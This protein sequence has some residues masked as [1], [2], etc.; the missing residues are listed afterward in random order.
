MR[1]IVTSGPSFSAARAMS[2][3]TSTESVRVSSSD[4]RSGRADRADSITRTGES[5]ASPVSTAS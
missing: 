4:Q 1:A 5:I 2:S 3:T